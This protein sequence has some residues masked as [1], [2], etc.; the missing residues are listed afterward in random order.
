M[1]PTPPAREAT[2]P[3]GGFRSPFLLLV[4]STIAACGNGGGLGPDPGDEAGVVRCTADVRRGTL[5]C[6]SPGVSQSPDLRG[7]VTIGGQGVLVLLESRGVCFEDGCDPAAPQ[8]IFQAEVTVRNLMSLALG[9]ADGW[10]ADDD[11]VRVFFHHGPVVTATSDGMAGMAA[12]HNADG[13]ATFTASDQPYFRYDGVIFPGETSDAKPWRWRLSPNVKAFEFAV[14][15]SAEVAEP[16]RGEP[17]VVFDMLVDGNR[18]LYRVRL[19]G[20]DFERLT[21]STADDREPTVAGDRVVFT[22][23]RDGNAEL[24]ALSLEAPGAAPVRLTNTAGGEREAALS[25]DGTRVAYISDVSKL[26]RLWLMEA[27]GSGAVPVTTGHGHSGAIEA[28]PSWAPDGTR[29]VFVSTTRGDADLYILDVASGEITP[30]VVSSKADVESSWSPDGAHVVF[31]SNRDGPT[32]LYRV[33][34]ATGEIEMLT[35]GDGPDG[36]PSYLPDGRIVYT[37]W[38]S[39]APA[40]RWLDPSRPGET[41]AIPLP[42]GTPGHPA[43]SGKAP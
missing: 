32:R 3:F 2:R 5:V 21:T 20:S 39:G 18:D 43:G 24:Y 36:Q 11:G 38:E 14:L 9:T 22:S 34:V 41:H 31:A 15:V 29:V 6:V 35:K 27:D 26:P 23:Y 40:L 4:V 19:D 17:F 10:S 1:R 28:S 13:T 7:A 33:A 25:P 30:L 37:S 16:A 12:V 42:A 8:G